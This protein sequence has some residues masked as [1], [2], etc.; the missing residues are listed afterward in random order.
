M[1]D[2]SKEDDEQEPSPN[3]PVQKKDAP[4]TPAGEIIVS[5]EEAAA[6]PSREKQI[7]RRRPLPPVPEKDGPT[8]IDKG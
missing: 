3:P 7:H 2:P 8:D 1:A 5:H 4:L 6:R